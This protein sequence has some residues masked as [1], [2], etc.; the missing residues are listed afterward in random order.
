MCQLIAYRYQ[1]LW[2]NRSYAEVDEIFGTSLR[3]QTTY[4]Y[5]QFL[6]GLRCDIER[7]LSVSDYLVV[8]F[9]LISNQVFL[10][11]GEVVAVLYLEY[12]FAQVNRF[13]A[14]ILMGVFHLVHGRMQGAVRRNDTVAAEVTVARHVG[15]EITSVCPERTSVL[16][17]GQNALVYPVPDVSAL[18]VRIFVDGFPLVP[19]ASGRVTHGMCVFRRSY[20]TVAATLADLFQPACTRVLRYVHVRV[21]FPLGAFVVHRTVHDVLVGFLYPQ[22]SLVEVVTVS[23]FVTQ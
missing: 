17:V 6:A 23:G 8:G 1:W 5:G 9:H 18:Q 15:T 19:K 10:Q 12:T 11:V 20:R 7:Y 21:P 2:F 14:Y 16:V 4:V 13:E 3:F 22:V